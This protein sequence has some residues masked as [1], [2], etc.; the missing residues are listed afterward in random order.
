MHLQL[1]NN[2]LTD[3]AFKSAMKR[4]PQISS[5]EEKKQATLKTLKLVTQKTTKRY[6]KDIIN[7]QGTGYFK[8][9][10]LIVFTIYETIRMAN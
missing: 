9:T 4:K 10:Q 2:P 1:Q 6:E 3:T 7:H 5:W 8:S